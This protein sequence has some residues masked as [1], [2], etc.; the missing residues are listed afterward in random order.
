VYEELF[1]L[2]YHGGY[3]LFESYNIPVG[4]R[5]WIIER[6]ISQMEK[7]KESLKSNRPG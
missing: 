1:V 5:R 6:L 4:L 3:S 2:K 7:E